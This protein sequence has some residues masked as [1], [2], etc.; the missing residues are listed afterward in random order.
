[1]TLYANNSGF[2]E[3]KSYFKQL[4]LRGREMGLDIFVFTPA[5]VRHSQHKIY[6]HHFNHNKKKW[7]RIMSPI[8]TLIF[9]RCRFQSTKRFSQLRQF[10]KRYPNLTYLNCPLA[11]KWRIHNVLYKNHRIRRYLP[12]TLKYRRYSDVLNLIEKKPSVY[13]KPINGTGGRGILKITKI[14]NRYH[15][16][17]RNQKRSIIHSKS[18]TKNGLISAC[19]AWEINKPMILQKGIDIRLENGRTHDYRLLMQKTGNGLWEMTGCAGR[20]G[21]KHSITSNLHG[22]GKAISMNTLMRYWF[23]DKSQRISIQQSIED[24]GF[25]VVHEM[26][27]KYGKLCELAL[28]IAVDRSGHSWL[29]EINPKPSRE[30]FSKINEPETYERALRRPLEYAIYKSKISEKV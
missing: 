12:T 17:G 15:I 18:V 28:D 29:L 3:E 4:I 11:N 1:M 5:D 13:L 24:L 2:I 10:R 25:L 27:R 16:Q 9:D 22:G 8:P 6:G 30:I 23:K 14:K 7:E 20:L 21:A 26:E 19:K